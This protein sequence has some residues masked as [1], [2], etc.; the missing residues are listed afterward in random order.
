MVGD[1][2]GPPDMTVSRRPSQMMANGWLDGTVVGSWRGRAV[3]NGG[4]GRAMASGE[5]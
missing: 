3:V 4:M 2:G 5:L 1:G